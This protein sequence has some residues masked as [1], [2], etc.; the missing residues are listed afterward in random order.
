VT[1]PRSKPQARHQAIASRLSTLSARARNGRLT[2]RELEYLDAVI[3]HWY[4]TTDGWR[5]EK[6]DG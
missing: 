6:S 1:A 4:E 3:T 2:E 5:A